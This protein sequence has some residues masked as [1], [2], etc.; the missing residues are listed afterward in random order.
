[1]AVELIGEW[2]EE[3]VAVEWTSEWGEKSCVGGIGVDR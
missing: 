3:K 2:G 1:M